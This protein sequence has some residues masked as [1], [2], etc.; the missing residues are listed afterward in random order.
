MFKESKIRSCPLHSVLLLPKAENYMSWWRDDGC[1]TFG[2]VKEKFK[3]EYSP[4]DKLHQGR[5]SA[6]CST[7]DSQCVVTG[8]E[9]GMVHV[10][11]LERDGKKEEAWGLEHKGA[12]CGHNGTITSVAVS[13][14]FGVVLSG[15]Q[16]G[17]VML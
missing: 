15:D 16:E 12:L 8:G 17:L 1:L 13:K 9:D 11:Q 5:V 6:I 10:W 2:L 3:N 7:T 4:I 14:E